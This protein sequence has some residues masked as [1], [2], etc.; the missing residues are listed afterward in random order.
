MLAESLQWKILLARFFPGLTDLPP[1]RVTRSIR[2]NKV[3]A[4]A[5]YQSVCL[6]PFLRRYVDA[7][8]LGGVGHNRREFNQCH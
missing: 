6:D 8:A 4:G 1:A 5:R 2:L 7:D 3:V